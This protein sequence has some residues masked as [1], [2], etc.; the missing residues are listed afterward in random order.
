MSNGVLS[1]TPVQQRIMDLLSDGL[2]HTRR[3]IH[4][5]LRDEQSKVSAIGVH[6]SDIRKKVLPTGYTFVCTLSSRK[7]R[8]RYV[9]LVNDPKLEPKGDGRPPRPADWDE[10]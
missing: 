1:F 3:E 8:Y 9:Q 7:I 4:G 10:R 2:P 6:I 5:C